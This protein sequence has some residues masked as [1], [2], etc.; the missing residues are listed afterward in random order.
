MGGV[1]L[2]E[3]NWIL[4][5]SECPGMQTFGKTSRLC[6]YPLVVWSIYFLKL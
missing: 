3:S 6:L 2:A 5:I 4:Y 1:G